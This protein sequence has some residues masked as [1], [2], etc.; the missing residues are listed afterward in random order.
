MG[1][2]GGWWSVVECRGMWEKS[3]FAW[4]LLRDVCLGCGDCDGM[5]W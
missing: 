4:L 1:C 3:G 2:G 5:F